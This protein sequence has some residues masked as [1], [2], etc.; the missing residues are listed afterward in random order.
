[1]L[2]LPSPAVTSHEGDTAQL[3]S[4]SQLANDEPEF[5]EALSDEVNQE[6]GME[7]SKEAGAGKAPNASLG[8]LDWILR[9]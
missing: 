2:S 1:M 3:K 9:S 5:K 4:E 6:M 8:T 7:M